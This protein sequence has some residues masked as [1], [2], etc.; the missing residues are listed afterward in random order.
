MKD[1]G[2][3]TSEKVAGA[4]DTA[5]WL[6]ELR[7]QADESEK[8]SKVTNKRRGMKDGMKLKNRRSSDPVRCCPT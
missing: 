6:S 8:E 3:E 1:D 5:T 2:I 4:T 7:Q